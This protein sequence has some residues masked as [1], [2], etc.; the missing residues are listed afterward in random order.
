MGI[1]AGPAHPDGKPS[2]DNPVLT[3]WHEKEGPFRLAVGIDHATNKDPRAMADTAGKRRLARNA[4][5]SILWSDL[6]DRHKRRGDCDIWTVGPQR[7]L[8]FLRKLANTMR[9][10][11]HEARAPSVGR[12][13]FADL[14]HHIE[15][16]VEAKPVTPEPGR[17]QNAG[18]AGVEEFR[19]RLSW[20]P[21]GFFCRL[22]AL[23]EVGNE[24]PDAVNDL[25]LCHYPARISSG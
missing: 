5:A 7:L 3:W 4:V 8:R 10:V 19:D 9:V 25:L 1:A 14:A 13:G 18:D 16:C 15:P 17:D 11:D 6:G 23:L 2:V 22:S 12:V 20:N 24:P 21:P